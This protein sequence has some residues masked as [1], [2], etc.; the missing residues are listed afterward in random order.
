MIPVA[1]QHVVVFQEKMII[2]WLMMLIIKPLD[3][4]TY[5]NRG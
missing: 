5:V 3:Y 1:G 2:L 4:R